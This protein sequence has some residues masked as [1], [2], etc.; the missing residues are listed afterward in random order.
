MLLEDYKLLLL[1]NSPH[2]IL[3]FELLLPQMRSAWRS[4]RMKDYKMEMI[5][6]LL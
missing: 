1:T 2:F 3:L 6:L 4:S 5:T